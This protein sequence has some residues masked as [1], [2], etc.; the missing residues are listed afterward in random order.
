MNTPLSAE[1]ARPDSALSL[2]PFDVERQNGGDAGRGLVCRVGAAEPQAGAAGAGHAGAEPLRRSFCSPA[3]GQ[4]RPE[5]AGEGGDRGSVG[6]YSGNFSSLWARLGR[7]AGG[8]AAL[9]SPT[10]RPP[11]SFRRRPPQRARHYLHI[12][13]DEIAAARRASLCALIAVAV[14][15]VIGAALATVILLVRP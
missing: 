2:I 12:A 11:R 6:F 5:D 15:P 4:G 7:A 10:V 9:T 3:D 1:R 13:A 8:R 14:S